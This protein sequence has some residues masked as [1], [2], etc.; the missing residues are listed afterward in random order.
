M[1]PSIQFLPFPNTSTESISD[2]HN[3]QEILL[4][5]Q[6]HANR[7]IQYIITVYMSDCFWKQGFMRFTHV[8]LKVLF[9]YFSFFVPD[10]SYCMN[11]HKSAK[12]VLWPCFASSSLTSKPVALKLCQ[13]LVLSVL[14]QLCSRL[15]SVVLNLRFSDDSLCWMP[16]LLLLALCY[17]LYLLSGAWYFA[18]FTG[19]I[20]WKILS[21]CLCVVRHAQSCLT[22]CDPVDCS[23]PGSSVHGISQALIL[24]WVIMP[25]SRGSSQSRAW[26]SVSF[27][28][29]QILYHCA[30]WEAQTCSKTKSLQIHIL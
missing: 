1:I 2:F 26:T 28:A 11:R 13:Y 8:F 22:V 20:G 15:L 10:H 27:T 16:S 30:T 4:L 25:S 29:R 12:A 18:C 9:V 5:L 7:T 23:L 3:Q 21:A 14:F 19:W 24:R 6:H 17:W